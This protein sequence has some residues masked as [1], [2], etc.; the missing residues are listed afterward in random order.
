MNKL[1]DKL[2]FGVSKTTN[3]NKSYKIYLT[4]ELNLSENE[5]QNLTNFK[6]VSRN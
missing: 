6:K 1:A 5:F 4:L 3:Y 2:K